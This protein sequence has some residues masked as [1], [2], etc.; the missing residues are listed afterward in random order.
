MKKLVIS[1]FTL[2]F[3]IS[4]V[5]FNVSAQINVNSLKNRAH[6]VTNKKKDKNKNSS[7]NNSNVKE[8]KGSYTSLMNLGSQK[9]TDGDFLSALKYYK[10]ALA[11]KTGDYSATQ[12]VKE[13]ESSVKDKYMNILNTEIEKGDCKNAKNNLDSVMA[14][15]EYWGQEKYYRGKIQKC[16]DNSDQKSSVNNKGTAFNSTNSKAGKIYFYKKF[17]DFQFSNNFL[18]SDELYAKIN[19]GKTMIDYSSE[20]GLSST[21]YAYGFFKFYINNKLVATSGP[22]SFSSDMSKVWKDFDIPLSINPD[23]AKKLK[24]HPE[25]LSTNKDIWLFQQLFVE[26]SINMQFTTAEILNLKNGANS[27]KVEFGLGEKDAKEPKGIV[28][29]G[30]MNIKM[31][32]TNKKELYNR[33]PKYLRPLDD[34]D[35]GNFKF[36]SS[37]LNIGS[38]PIS[39]TLELPNPP[40]FYNQYWCKANTCDYDHGNLVF[41]AELD[42]KF[43]A[44]WS[45]EF[46]GDAYSKQK[47]FN[48]TILPAND[49]KLEDND[50]PFNSEDLFKRTTVTNPLPYAMFDQIYSGLMKAGNH[51]LK[52]K[53]YS[54]E[55]VP[56]S[57]TF[58]NT[59]EYH[60]KWRSI[61]ETTVNLNLTNAARQ[62]LIASSIA[63]KLRHAG[64]IW[65]SV[66]N[67]LKTSQTNANAVIIDVAA[68]TK[69]KITVNVLGVPIYRT[70]RADILYKTAAGAY[71]INRA[72]VVKED[73]NGGS[74]GKP[75][76]TKV[77]DYNLSSFMLS[78]AH[79]PVPGI[80]VK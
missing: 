57:A 65:T 11:K 36:A 60:N 1:F 80:K 47:S 14:V 55:S 40:K 68:N 75:Y 42:G 5:N 21:F 69:W 10:A 53:V 41:Y 9:K 77:M 15:M 76:F 64:G 70:C 32:N 18:A 79:F 52:L 59:K 63:K 2:F 35:R 58:E 4:T 74:Y 66:D 48:L 31:D 17:K 61:A 28:A 44:S 37:T 19:M 8:E 23:F 22:Y 7:Q 30:E 43:F 39:C 24:A 71:R 38:S 78:P 45:T 27:V 56:Y 3:I 73:Y 25:L 46:D 49:S 16:L 12:K 72:V 6:K 50:A 67:H 33:G 51:T 62:H 20:L 54:N 29:S 13:M 34:K 26:N